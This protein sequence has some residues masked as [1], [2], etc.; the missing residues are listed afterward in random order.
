M[1]MDVAERSA[2][3]VDGDVRITIARVGFPVPCRKN[4]IEC[5]KF[6]VKEN[7][8]MKCEDAHP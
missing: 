3:R 5:A 1:G 7:D 6:L 2:T 4:F 8:K